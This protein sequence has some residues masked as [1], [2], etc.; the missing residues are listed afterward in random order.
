V[1]GRKIRVISPNLIGTFVSAH[2][3]YNKAG[4]QP[5]LDFENLVEFYYGP[6]YRFAMSL[7][8][9]ESDAG[10]LVQ[11]TFLAWAAKGHQLRDTSKVKPWLFT[12]LHR[13]FLELQ[14]RGTRFAQVEME[15][16][17]AE[18]PDVD[19]ELV[20]RMDAQTVVQTL[21]R[22]D[23]QFQAAVALFYLEDYS[24]NDIAMILD[25]PLG[26]VKSRIAR[27][28]TQLRALMSR[29]SAK[30]LLPRKEP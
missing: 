20:D 6:L 4:Q 10:D 30:P 26:T 7:T 9:S 17:A 18:L 27:G 12:T 23:P 19:A 11:D 22:V 24:Y 25:V 14:R 2:S 28:L 15:E 29:R 13:R 16:A 1:N 21:E 8:R 5:E 3:S